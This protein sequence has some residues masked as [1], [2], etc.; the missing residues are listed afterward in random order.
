MTHEKSNY[1]CLVIHYDEQGNILPQCIKCA[2]CGQWIRPE[3][4]D[5][6]CPKDEYCESEL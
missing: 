2:K 6:S 5:D 4:L 3:N 1:R